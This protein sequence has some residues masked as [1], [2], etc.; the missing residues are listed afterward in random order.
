M[1]IFIC[2]LILMLLKFSFEF[3]NI[4]RDN[5]DTEKPN[6]E[7]II[8]E[9]KRYTSKI[10]LY[11]TNNEILEEIDKFMFKPEIKKIKKNRKST[12]TQKLRSEELLISSSNADQIEYFK[13][14]QILI[15]KMYVV[16]KS[17]FL[18]SGYK[19]FYENVKKLADII[20]DKSIHDN[21]F[22]YLL[23]KIKILKE[24]Y[25]EIPSKASILKTLLKEWYT[26][27]MTLKYM[28]KNSK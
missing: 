21:N 4:R 9:P 10:H 12:K 15:N 23:E 18:V 27:V 5:D 19:L 14:E 22:E 28:L 2:I 1:K 3:E 25:E 8:E 16:E 17:D 24:Y 26:K 11:K 6:E 13:I 20:S 7:E